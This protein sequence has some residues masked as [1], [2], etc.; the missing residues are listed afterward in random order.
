M[1]VVRRPRSRREGPRPVGRVLSASS[2]RDRARAHGAVRPRVSGARCAT[3]GE[4]GRAPCVA[5]ATTDAGALITANCALAQGRPLFAIPGD[6]A[7]ELSSG[8]N[9]LIRAGAARPTR[10]ARELLNLLDWTVG[11]RP[12]TPTVDIPPT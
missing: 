10:A 5:R 3:G 8:P 2:R 7:D 1:G 9:G 6:P 11:D 12:T 4:R